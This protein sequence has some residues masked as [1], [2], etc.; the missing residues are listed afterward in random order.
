[1]IAVLAVTAT[2]AFMLGRMKRK[3]ARQLSNKALY[4]SGEIN[5]GDW[6]SSLAGI[7]G[8]FGI[9]FGYWWA[10]AGAAGLIALE[11]VKDGY[12]SLRN[13]VAQLMNKRPSDVESKEKDPIMDRVQHALE[14]LDWVDRARVRLREEGDL[15][16]GEAF[17]VPRDEAHLLDRLEQAS[18]LLHSL[19]WRLH[20]VSVVP[21]RSLD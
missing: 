1:M 16:S 20:D 14:E 21:L 2:P 15:L 5:E 8:L 18:E 11:I 7:A 6:L 17:V 13:S 19:D 12:Q 4:T 9:S 3:V 10:D